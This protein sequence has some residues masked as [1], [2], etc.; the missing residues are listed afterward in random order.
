MTI[1]HCKCCNYLSERKGNY[2]KHLATKKHVILF[3]KSNKNEINE[4]FTKELVEENKLFDLSQ[5]I[6]SFDIIEKNK[7][8]SNDNKF[9]NYLE[10]NKEIKNLNFFD[11]KETDSEISN[12][13]QYEIG[14]NYDEKINKCKYCNKIFKYPQGLSKHIKYS[15]KR[16]QD[17][18]MQELV[19][20]L[21]EQNRLLNERVTSNSQIQ[22]AKET[23]DKMQKQISKLANKLKIHN[24]TNAN[25]TFNTLNNTSN[26]NLLGYENTNYSCI[27]ERE[28]VKCIKDCNF[29]VKSFIEKVHFNRRYPENMNIYISSIKANYI[30]VYRDGIW[31]IVDKK[32]H[33]DN[34]YEDNEMQIESWFDEYKETYPEIINSFTR[35]LHNRETDEVLNQVKKEILRMLYNKRNLVIDNFK[36]YKEQKEKEKRKYEKT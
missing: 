26:I 31:N 23:N 11:I 22:V 27:S 8:M 24:V 34:M 32:K 21:N 25:N 19:R 6:P 36:K 12:T 13:D 28:M 29:C 15:C 2:L 18:D 4:C 35:Y 7:I 33:I 1:Y 5:N 17:E 10:D 16:S 30:M 3:K 9:F 20:L 14:S